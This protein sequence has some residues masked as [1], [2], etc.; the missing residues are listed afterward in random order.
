MC[1]AEH[2]SKVTK[3]TIERRLL[4][5]EGINNYKWLRFM[6]LVASFIRCLFSAVS[7]LALGL[8]QPLIK[9]VS[10]A[11]P[12]RVRRPGYEAD[13]APPS[14]AEARNGKVILPLPLMSSG[15]ST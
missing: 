10:R 9:W 13:H 14:S 1:F 15:N 11:I 6:L 4:S 5:S 8:T 7:R 2:I 12:Q 3:S